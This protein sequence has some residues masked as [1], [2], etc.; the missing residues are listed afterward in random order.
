MKVKKQEEKT[1]KLT[2]KL[3]ERDSDLGANHARIYCILGFPKQ[4][5]LPKV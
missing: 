3:V 2:M 1:N 4:G 5:W